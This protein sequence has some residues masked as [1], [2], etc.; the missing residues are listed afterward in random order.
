[1]TR[2]GQQSGGADLR[3]G[4]LAAAML[5]AMIALPLPGAAQQGSGAPLSAIDWLQQ[6][7]E[8][9]MPQPPWPDGPG[10]SDSREGSAATALLPDTT[11]TIPSSAVVTASLS[12]DARDVAGLF[13]AERAGLPRDLWAAIPR[14]EVIAAIA[15]LPTDTLP[16]AM[17]LTLRLLLA[18]FAPPL[19]DM[20]DSRDALLTARLDKLIA[21]GALEQAGQLIAAVPDTGAAL[22]AR[23]FD[24]ALL[25]GEEDRACAQ[26]Q[27]R[28]APDIGHAAQVFCM[29][30]RGEWQAA[31]ASLM[32]ARSLRLIPEPEAGLLA[33]FLEEE[34]AEAP[35]PPPQQTTPLGWRIMEAL[36]DPVTTAGLPVAY[37][38]ADL[39]GTSG[40]RAQLDA[41][42]RL[43][44]AGVLQ[45]NRLHGLYTQRRAAASGGLW[46]RVR[47]VQALERAAARG[48]TDVVAEVLIT[49]WPLF[50]AVE[51]EVAFAETHAAAL[52]NLPLTGHA[53][54]IQWNLLVLAQ[55]DPARAAELM[56]EGGVGPL[57]MALI[58]E[59]ELPAVARAPMAQAIRDGFSA[60]TPPEDVQ[61]QI[62]A[63]ATGM[64]L[65]GAL[66]ALAQA[67]V[68]DVQ[69]ANAGLQG[70]RALGLDAVARQVAIELLLLERRG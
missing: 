25:L 19:D 65:R 44:R 53:G 67:A 55:E 24:I 34:E 48:D 23:A 51:L 35:P 63:G 18:E 61:T 33:R 7:L 50:V 22:D 9:P 3:G 68:G 57:V 16:S 54:E 17:R 15:E 49:A 20:P 39:R 40:W 59:R 47:A 13:T 8:A 37:A 56:P 2:V 1:M 43:T 38:H 6:A 45:S 21:L 11:L 29:A 31:H 5:L 30:R 52:A 42:E 4:R 62:D 58:E 46:E 32:V 64:V 69:A 27:G 10:V 28:I 36:G 66:G 41:A 14:S 60:A 26:M 12:G 70:L